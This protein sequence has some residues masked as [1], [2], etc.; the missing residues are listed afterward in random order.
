[1]LKEKLEKL[2]EFKEETL[3][4]ECMKKNVELFKFKN[5]NCNIDEK[6]RVLQLYKN[7]NE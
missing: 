3:Y 2:R 4:I 6:I 7:S 5:E 1:M